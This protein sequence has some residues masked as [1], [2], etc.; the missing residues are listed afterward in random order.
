MLFSVLFQIMAFLF[1]MARPPTL[2][3]RRTILSALRLAL[4]FA[5]DEK[6]KVDCVS[7]RSKFGLTLFVRRVQSAR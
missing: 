1:W 2:A 4:R 6:T 5:L 7:R 3:T